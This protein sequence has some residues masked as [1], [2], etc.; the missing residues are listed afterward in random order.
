MLVMFWANLHV[1]SSTLHRTCWPSCIAAD[2]L[3]MCV[4]NNE[5]RLP[6]LRR[7]TALRPPTSMR[8]HMKGR[9]APQ[10]LSTIGV[11]SLP[12]DRTVPSF[13]VVSWSVI[14][15]TIACMLGVVHTLPSPAGFV[16]HLASGTMRSTVVLAHTLCGML[17][18]CNVG[19]MYST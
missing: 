3:L 9:S 19:R 17:R 11:R 10:T 5:K 8:F 12:A 1:A 7:I 18:A 15:G 2:A 16:Q 6:S 4:I 14:C 13:H